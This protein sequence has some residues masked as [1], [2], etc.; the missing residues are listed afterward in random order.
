VKLSS[1]RMRQLAEG[2]MMLVDAPSTSPEL[3]K[4]AERK[5]REIR[6]EQKR[7]ERDT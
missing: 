3:R 6:A 4:R 1:E 7:R 5:L 2:A